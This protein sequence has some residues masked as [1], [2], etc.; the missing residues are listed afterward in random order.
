MLIREVK[1]TWLAIIIAVIIVIAIGGI[2]AAY[3]QGDF[4]GTSTTGK[5][6]YFT[7]IEDSFGPNKGMNGSAYHTLTSS[8]PVM[9]VQLGDNVVI[10]VINNSTVEPHGFTIDHYFNSGVSVR[11]GQSYDVKF[12]A[13]QAGTFRVFC[14]IQCSI[15]PLMQNGTLIVSQ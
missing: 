8:W 1:K 7:I 9:Q 14:D 2:V 5:T 3:Y 6:V 13:N 11:P 12:T 15:H 10:H 4:T